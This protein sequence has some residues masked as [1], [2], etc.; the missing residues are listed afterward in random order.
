VSIYGAAQDHFKQA[1]PA[2][3]VHLC[4]KES[5]PMLI[6]GDFNI[7]RGPNEK[8]NTNYSDRWPFFVQCHNRCGQFERIRII[9]ETVHLG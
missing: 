3:L 7:I 5:L 2:E 4:S 9:R 6:G 8:N 1:F